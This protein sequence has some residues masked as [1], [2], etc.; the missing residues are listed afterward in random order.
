MT[1]HVKFDHCLERASSLEQYGTHI[2][3]RTHT[4]TRVGEIAELSLNGLPPH[5]LGVFS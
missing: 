1:P 4:R 2:H 5:L 3:E